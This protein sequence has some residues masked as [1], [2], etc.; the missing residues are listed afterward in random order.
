[1]SSRVGSRAAPASRATH[2]T[3][4]I[5]E[6]TQIP[7]IKSLVVAHLNQQIAAFSTPNNN[8]K[9]ELETRFHDIDIRVYNRVLDFLKDT[10]AVT[11]ET[12]VATSDRT[13]DGVVYRK[14]TS[15]DANA[16][17]VMYE[18]KILQSVLKVLPYNY[19]IAKSIEQTISEPKVVYT[20]E[21]H[22]VRKTFSF[23]NYQIDVTEIS[24]TFRDV[25]KP[26]TYEIEIEY[27]TG[28]ISAYYDAIMKI[29]L[30]IHDTRLSYTVPMKNRIINDLLAYLN[31]SPSKPNKIPKG[32]VPT[33]RNLKMNDLVYG[34]IVGNHFTDYS[35]TY[36]PDGVRKLPVTKTSGSA[37]TIWYDTRW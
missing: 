30:A 20:M 12:T 10:P 21:R 16:E 9:I 36:K 23:T 19:N 28:D 1:M 2:T 32:V 26:N 35:V 24:T 37:S 34:G 29:Y 25:Y 11:T 7:Q 13:N 18:K 3:T 4:E 22:R 5:P 14:I 27:K 8:E 6:K 33:T 15:Y 17:T 31:T